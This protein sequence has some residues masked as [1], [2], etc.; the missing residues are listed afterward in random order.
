MKKIIYS[1]IT[2]FLLTGVVIGNPVKESKAIVTYEFIFPFQNEHVHGS[3]IVVLPNGDMLAVW[4][5]G[6]GERTADDVRIMG[7]RLKN[8]KM[9]FSDF[10]QQLTILVM[11]PLYGSGR[12][13]SFLNPMR[14]L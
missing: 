9:L 12:M 8:G 5:Q 7:A 10:A 14:V 1:I 2:S 6:S 4:F 13:I 11:R 3:S